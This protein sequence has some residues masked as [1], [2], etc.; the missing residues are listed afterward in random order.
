M[1]GIIVEDGIA[2]T[3]EVIG[4]AQ[5]LRDFLDQADPDQPGLGIIRDEHCH[6]VEALRSLKGPRA[7]FDWVASEGRPIERPR[8]DH[9]KMRRHSRAESRSRHKP[10][11]HVMRPGGARNVDTCLSTQSGEELIQETRILRCATPHQ[12]DPDR[13][14]I[15]QQCW[16]L[17]APFQIMRQVYKK[18]GKAGV[19]IA[20]RSHGQCCTQPGKP[21]L[22]ACRVRF[23]APA[24]WG[25]ARREHC[26]AKPKAS[27]PK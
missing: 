27:I 16:P 13:R 18:V 10:D 17:R 4:R 26:H 3:I 14:L 22:T 2:Q 11:Q 8:C 24:Q 5:P 20:R 19:R 21:R 23:V 15:S 7:I 25:V 12:P 1:R 6:R 9:A